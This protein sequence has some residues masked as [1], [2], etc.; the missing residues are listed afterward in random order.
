MG[1]TRID[2]ALS[3]I[4]AAFARLDRAREGSAQRAALVQEAEKR[5]RDKDASGSARVMALV[6]SHEKLREEVADTLGDLD[7]LIADLEER[8]SDA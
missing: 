1:N 8:A 7:E 6:N 3:R 4:D 2:A 5:A